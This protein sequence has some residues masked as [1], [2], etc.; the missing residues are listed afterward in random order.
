MPVP[1]DQIIRSRRKTIALY[2]T[3]QGKVVVRAPLGLPEAD[4]R[5]LVERK[6]AWVEGKLT[7][8]QQQVSAQLNRFDQGREIY[9]LG[10]TYP[11][12]IV[13]TGRQ[14][15]TFG[16][17]F[18]LERRA[19]PQAELI[20][21]RWF[22]AQARSILGER[23]A[24]LA[25]QHSFTFQKVRITSAR[26]RWGSCSSRGSISFP[27]RLVMAPPEVIDYVVLH[28]LAHLKVRNHSKRFWDLVRSLCPDYA[29]Q[30]GWLKKYG[31]LLVL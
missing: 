26:T 25:A 12:R 30:R 22:R 21:E 5:A 24:Q 10:K 16:T 18:N 4:I 6:A 8:A 27:W 13:E 2:I 3:A 29:R 9:F 11:L 1:I 7:Q 17:H 20:F 23:T 19:L 14:L 28:E 31:A 15:L